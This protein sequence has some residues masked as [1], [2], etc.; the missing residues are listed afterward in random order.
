MLKKSTGRE[1]WAMLLDDST[2]IN[3]AGALTENHLYAVKAKATT[4]GIPAGLAVGDC[5]FE[6]KVT[7]PATQTTLVSGDIVI[8]LGTLFDVTTLIG[9]A[10]SKDIT[11]TKSTIDMTVD[12]DLSDVGDIR[13]DPIVAVSGNINGYK[14]NNL[15]STSASRKMPSLVS[16][17]LLTTPTLSQLLTRMTSR[18]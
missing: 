1:V 16:R 8:D 7:S 6:V 17:F 10:R 9:Y 15:P 13:V 18:H 12:G 2:E 3:T 14:V 4:S 5:W 11:R